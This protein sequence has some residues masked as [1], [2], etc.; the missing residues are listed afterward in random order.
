MNPLLPLTLKQI[1]LSLQR[2]PPEYATMSIKLIK[3]RLVKIRTGQLL[4]PTF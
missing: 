2:I 1:P 4:K 3:I